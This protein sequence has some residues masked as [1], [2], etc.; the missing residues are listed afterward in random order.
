MLVTA[1]ALVPASLTYSVTNSGVFARLDHKQT[2]ERVCQKFVGNP[3]TNKDSEFVL[4][5]SNLGKIV[6]INRSLCN[7]YRGYPKS[8]DKEG[9]R[10]TG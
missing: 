6:K 1:A 4:F 9:M 3:D 7:D 2:V 5:L 8:A 10:S